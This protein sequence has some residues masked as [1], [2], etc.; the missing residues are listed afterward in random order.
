[1]VE[2]TF[3]RLIPTPAGVSSLF[4]EVQ[5]VANKKHPATRGYNSFFIG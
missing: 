5:E 3:A 2:S 1:M 4:F